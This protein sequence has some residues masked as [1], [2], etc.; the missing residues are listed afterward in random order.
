M[1]FKKID[2]VKIDVDGYELDVLK[3]GKKIITKSKPIIYFIILLSVLFL[4]N[5]REYLV[6]HTH[7]PLAM[8]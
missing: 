6:F 3:S 2:F 5:L 1:L 8:I 7:D 4:D